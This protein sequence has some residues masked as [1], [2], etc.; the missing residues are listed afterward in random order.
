M[1]SIAKM[2]W[3]L[4]EKYHV[5]LGKLSPWVFAVMIGRWPYKINRNN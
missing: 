1:K 3:K 5:N 2:I 4:A